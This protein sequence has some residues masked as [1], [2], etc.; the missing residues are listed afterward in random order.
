MLVSRSAKRR[1]VSRPDAIIRISAT[2]VCG[3]DSDLWRIA[4]LQG[5]LPADPEAAQ[6]TAAF[7]EEV[8]SAVTSFKPGQFVIGSFF[9]SRIELMPQLPDRLSVL[10]PAR[11]VRRHGRRAHCAGPLADGT[12]VTTPEV[13][14]ARCVPEL[15]GALR[16]YGHG[17][18]AADWRRT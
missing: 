4:A 10:L 3:S 7:V 16:R 9:A 14:R 8:G 13:I 6:T 18:F 2:C 1:V 17:W 15:V 11:G 5:R 12:L